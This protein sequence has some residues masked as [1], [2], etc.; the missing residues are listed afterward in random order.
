MKRTL[1]L[2]AVGGLTAEAFGIIGA[3]YGGYIAVFIGFVG[4]VLNVISAL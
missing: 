4:G 2:S 3:V 1:Y